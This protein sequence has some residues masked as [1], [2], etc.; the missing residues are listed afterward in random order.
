MNPAE[1]TREV[2]WN[3]VYGWVVYI[4]LVPTLAIAGYG[5]Y[6]RVRLWR[7]GQPTR[8]WDCPQERLRLLWHHA[9]LQRRNFR[10]RFAGIFHAFIFWGVLTLTAATTVVMIHHDFGLPIMQGGILSVLS[11]LVCRCTGVSRD[12]R[13]SDVDLNFVVRGSG[14][15]FFGGGLEDRGH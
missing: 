11:I 4:L 14:F 12:H 9:M 8:R 2:F 15:R 10:D 3:I 1:A 6:R 5:V 13:R 7:Q